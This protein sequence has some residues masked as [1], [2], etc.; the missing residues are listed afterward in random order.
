[1][2]HA[3]L[4]ILLVATSC[5]KES[6]VFLCTPGE[7]KGCDCVGGSKG[8]QICNATGDGLGECLG[9]PGG[10]QIDMSMID[11]NAD[12]SLPPQ[13]DF[14]PGTDLTGVDLLIPPGSDLTF[15]PA[16]M[17]VVVG[18]DMSLPPDLKPPID[19]LNADLVG[20][21][22]TPCGVVMLVL[23]ASGSMTSFLPGTS[24]SRLDAA[25]A[26]LNK[27]VANYGGR[28]PFGLSRFEASAASCDVGATIPVEPMFGTAT[29]IQNELAATVAGGGTNTGNMIKKVAADPAMHDPM[30]QGSFMILVTDGAP[31]CESNDPQFTINEVDKAAKAAKPIKTFVIG[32][33]V[34]AGDE[35]EMELMAIAGQQPC[36]SGFCGGKR[37]YPVKTTADLDKALDLIMN[38]IVASAPG[39]TCGGFACFPAG[40]AC[41]VGQSCCGTAGC[42]NLL[43]GDTEN[44]G[45]CG[46]SCGTGA[47]CSGGQCLCGGLA[48][49]AGDKCCNGT[50]CSKTDML[51]PPDLL[52]APPDLRNPDLGLPSCVCNHKVCQF[53]CVAANC[54]FEDTIGAPSL[55]TA[56]PTVCQC[57]G[58]FP[59]GCF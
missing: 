1:M 35:A 23:D 59:F 2:R 17:T 30:R 36:T 26:G 4:L 43:S 44:C 55:C 34:L 54:C 47:T 53:G 3:A 31:L 46:T 10:P 22:G 11:P 5:T 40:A 57:S 49:A 52:S 32:M 21:M 28:V 24:T 45:E 58:G 13:F 50:C 41:G 8:V 14:P 19:L 20:T 56:T 9:C 25:R 42:K 48:C 18:P 27:L 39:G 7:Q 51:P 29:A 6:G 15:T 16:D 12:M 38:K 37:Y 33:D